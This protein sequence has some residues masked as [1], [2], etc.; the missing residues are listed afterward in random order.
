MK[1]HSVKR[2]LKRLRLACLITATTLS[3]GVI[4]AA[5][6]IAAPARPASAASAEST[7][8]GSASHLYQT[9]AQA[10]EQAH[11]T[12]KA[13]P[14]T[15]ATTP[16]STLTAEP[17]GAFTY[18]ESI[19][20]T[21]TKIDGA[22]KDLDA[23]LVRNPGG[24][25]SPAVSTIPL[26]VSGSGTGPL[27][28]L[29]YG[30]YTLSMAAPARLPAPVIS[31]DTA[32]YDAIARGIDLI[33]TVSATGSY[34]ESLRID[35]AKAA[36]SPA[37]AALD[38]ATTAPGLDMTAVEDGAVTA[39]TPRGQ[40]LFTAPA[41]R[42]WDS[43]MPSGVKTAVGPDGIR[44]DARTGQA[45]SSSPVIP[46]TGA[47]TA[48]LGVTVRGDRLTLAPNRALL[49][50]KD[51]VFP[52]YVDPDW[53][54]NG[55]S[56]GNWAYVSSDNASTSNYDSNASYLQVGTNPETGGTSYSF[57]QFPVP[58]GITGDSTVNS[59]TLY[60]TEGWSESCAPEPDTLYQTG[61]FSS[62]TTYDDPPSWGSSIGTDSVAYDWNEAGVFGDTNPATTACPGGAKDV[63]YSIE[64]I[65]QSDANMASG[66][67]LADLDVGMQDP[68]GW[69]QFADTDSPDGNAAPATMT[70]TYAFPPATPILSTS[71]G[72]NCSSNPALVGDGN[73]TLRALATEKA[74]TNETIASLNVTFAAYADGNTGD[75][76]LTNS[77]GG[78]V[79]SATVQEP[80]NGTAYEVLHQSALEKA[81]TSDAGSGGEVSITF[82]AYVS[83]GLSG[84]ANSATA[85]CT[86]TFDD[87]IPGAPTLSSQPGDTSDS[88]PCDLIS[89][90]TSPVTAGTPVTAY[91]TANA[92]TMAQAPTTYVYQL[93]GGSPLTDIAGTNSPYQGTLTV[94]PTR[95]YNVLTVTEIAASGNIGQATTC[96]IYAQLP[97]AATDQDLTGDGTPDLLTVG[98]GTTGDASGLWVAPGQANASG[99]FDGTVNA[100]ATDI[101]P[102][103]PQG[104]GI[105]TCSANSGGPASW[106]GFQATT[107]QYAGPGFNAV[108]AYCPGTDQA[109]IVPTTGD[110]SV[111]TSAYASQ[112]QALGSTFADINPTSS[113]E[114]YPV[115]LVDAY[116]VSTNGQGDSEPY[117]DQIGMYDDSQQGSYLAYFVNHGGMSSF[118][119]DG[120]GA[121]F[122]LMN[123]STGT[124]L[125]PPTGTGWADWTITTAA[126]PAGTTTAAGA[127]VLADM[128]LLNRSSGA[129]YLWELTGLPQAS[130]VPGNPTAVNVT[131]D[132]Q[133]SV[134]VIN[135]SGTASLQYTQVP[136]S[137]PSCAT[138]GNW[139]CGATLNTLQAT[140][141]ACPQSLCPTTGTSPVLTTGLIDVTSAGQ[142]QSLAIAVNQATPSGTAQQVNSASTT[143][144]LDTADHTYLLN[145]DAS[146]PVT[147][148]A[149]TPGDGDTEDDLGQETTAY[150]PTGNSADTLFSPDVTFNG[151]SDHLATS[152]ALFDP[153]S[154]FTVSA[155]VNLAALGGTI[156][157]QDGSDY[158]A[159][160]VGATT[161]GQWSVSMETANGASTYNAMTTGTARV[162]MWTNIIVTYDHGN[163]DD[164]LTLYVNGAEAGVTQDTT[165]PSST[166]PFR[167]GAAYTDKGFDSFLNGQ[168]ADVQ[169]W[170]SLAV[171]AQVSSPAS[172]YVPVTPVRIL[173]T[174]AA[175]PLNDS[176]TGPVASD[177]IVNVPIIGNGNTSDIPTGTGGVTA[178]EVSV[179]VTGQTGGGF[180]TAFPSGTARPVTSTL[181]YPDSG[182]ISNS[183]IVPLGTNGDISFYNS[184]ADTVQIIVDLMGYFTTNFP[185]GTGYSSSTA[186]GNASTYLPLADPVRLFNTTAGTGTPKATVAADSALTITIDGNTTNGADIPASGVTA[187]ALDIG[188]SAPSGDNGY[189]AAYPDGATR[190]A[191][192]N[193]NFTGGATTYATTVI[194]PVS[195]TDGEID[196]Y[197]GSADPIN[198]VGDL[199]GYFTDSA[200]T[201]GQYYHAL[202]STRILDTRQT[203][204]VAANGTQTV[205]TPASILADNPTLVLNLTVTE[206]E[207]AGY[208]KVYPNGAA[209]P[210]T[211]IS[212]FSAGDVVGAM[213]LINTSPQ[214]EFVVGNVSSGTTEVVLDAD[215]YFA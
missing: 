104:D 150:Q 173:D 30:G 85:S 99:Q 115:Q 187:V 116:D 79:S 153:N 92:S 185:G 1:S 29:S 26:T 43:A 28:T 196:L 27:A 114:D 190:G 166:G 102:Y 208:L 11:R 107:G 9:P 33:L 178:A 130:L 141:V 74:A 6:A 154:S 202:N 192:S 117:P 111:V 75:S 206:P 213:G 191:E 163:G 12:G 204:A 164:I 188:A 60:F 171:P 77:S 76:V 2:N 177:T 207:D 45:V 15:A 184:S 215:G 152:S 119:A 88:E 14:I 186:P 39:R 143:Q 120:D 142:V 17:D 87:A 172:E 5:P 57:W 149:D 24:T 170:D 25:W 148:A 210:G 174:R 8:S 4:L 7:P 42:M 113:N 179:T 62:A 145:Q 37:L 211:S 106:N 16:T 68:D 86:F 125:E 59:A 21:R 201:P 35:N 161:S 126:P 198:L 96:P 169:V 32:T 118:D 155:W 73:V 110:G 112:D 22:W 69:L 36:A 100:S 183:A 61:G 10:S 205:S 40:V 129:L 182:S 66:T 83:A 3:C 160:K 180:L 98:S 131:V 165:P 53:G 80:N 167:V 214:N 70:I 147:D 46:G 134:E 140:T 156:F 55:S 136:I 81:V 135:S 194:V 48:P 13:V 50:A 89:S 54:A 84:L 34:S 108:E 124:Y 82:T 157:S 138:G 133:S 158:S 212:D 78:T 203:S 195:S 38:F 19:A 144:Q 52:E 72:G 189:V 137:V 159:M 23:S 18:S 175:A 200:T 199:S 181:N 94:T 109:Y 67:K 101:D 132:G 51:A 176:I 31:G 127:T 146:G 121:P 95:A 65:I 20:P 168:L 193:I 139:T 91:A 162:D 93:N 197:N 103:G 209:P 44:R 90:P 41:P 58:D 123:P 49:T 64:S 122:E 105:S 151:T 56:A 71:T 97:A 63:A 128:Y 47:H